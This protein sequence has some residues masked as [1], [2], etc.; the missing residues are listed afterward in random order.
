[1]INDFFFSLVRGALW[2]HD[3]EKGVVI[4][5]H[6]LKG[7]I[8]MAKKQSL[9]GLVADGILNRSVEGMSREM[10]M[11]LFSYQLSVEKSNRL[12][13]RELVA[14]ASLLQQN[15]IRFC[16]VKGQVAGW[17]Y[18]NPMLRS[19]GDI[20]VYC[21]HRDVEKMK[22]LLRERGIEIVDDGS[23]R[24]FSFVHQG[25]EFE[26]HYKLANFNTGSNQRYWDEMVEG[27]VLHHSDNIEID[28][29]MIPTL[30][31]TM[32]VA[33][34]FVHLYHHFLKEGVGLRQLCDWA[35]V[36]NRLHQKIDRALL[37][38]IL[39]RLGYLKAYRVMGCILTDR[40]GLPAED[41]PYAIG[42][43]DRGYGERILKEI[44]RG[45]NFGWYGRWTSKGGWLHSMETGSISLRH[46]IGYWR[47]S[48]KENLMFVPIQAWRSI[49]KNMKR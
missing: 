49:T 27:D 6:A 7:V 37:T 15:N 23:F 42:R 22:S 36:M 47:L 40:L 4:D 14:F 39:S 34:V 45:G 2:G 1:M 16:V 46:C 3:S 17:L 13:N 10:K 9:L 18:R 32:N 8:D 11:T 24:H 19:A 31:P 12:V 26:I 35:M 29:T 25:V 20:D 43:N 33:F 21:A 38:E 5:P 30:S 28:G 48:P 41:F 44:L